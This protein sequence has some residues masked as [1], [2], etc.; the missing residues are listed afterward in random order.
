MGAFL[1]FGPDWD[2]GS[3]VFIFEPV[4]FAILV[5]ALVMPALFGLINA[6]V[7][8]R[9]QAFRGRPAAIAALVGIAALYLFR[10]TEHARALTLAAVN[11][12]QNASRFF[13]SPHP[14]DPFKWSLVRETPAAYQLS[15][16]DTRTGL[17]ATSSPGDT[18]YKAPGSL[19]VLAAK[20]SELGRVYLDWSMFPVISETPDNT[21]PHRTLT[22]VTFADARFMYN[23]V[24]GDGREHPAITGSVLLDMQAPEGQRV[25][26]TRMDGKLQK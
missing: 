8:V 13:A 21:D 18:V 2:A 14:G 10:Y 7:G 3:F 17:F 23:T 22:L 4:L 20:R 19:A 9:K 6:E 15:T 12:D 26:E 1:P 16:V 11:A 5:L 24:L 25:I